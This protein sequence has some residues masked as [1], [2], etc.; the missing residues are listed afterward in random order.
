MQRAFDKETSHQIGLA[1]LSLQDLD[2]VCRLWSDQEAVKYTNW[3][4]LETAAECKNRLREVLLF[5]KKNPLHFGPYAIRLGREG[6]FAGIIGA[7]VSH[8]TQG[9]YEVWYFLQREHWGTGLARQTL[10]EILGLMQNSGRVKQVVATCV[11][12]NIASWKLLE[13]HGFIRQELIPK[14]FQRNG[15]IKDLLKYAYYFSK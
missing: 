1:S 8:Q 5:Y 10:A 9:I 13:K 2:G 15:Q 14:G 6:E 3:S 12:D 11:V 4:Y 7:D